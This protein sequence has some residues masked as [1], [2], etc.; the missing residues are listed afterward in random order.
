VK[1][2]VEVIVEKLENGEF[3]PTR[4]VN[5]LQ[6]FIIEPSQEEFGTGPFRLTFRVIDRDYILARSGEFHFPVLSKFRDVIVEG[7]LAASEAPIRARLP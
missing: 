3:R 1:S 6:D 4:H 7:S 5:P 2:H